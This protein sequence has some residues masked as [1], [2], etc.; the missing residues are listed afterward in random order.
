MTNRKTSTGL[1]TKT[2]GEIAAAGDLATNTRGTYERAWSE[3]ERWCASKR[4]STRPGRSE[5][6]RRR[7]A[8][9]IID[10]LHD[11]Y[12]RDISV[13]GL[14]IRRNAIAWKLRGEISVRKWRDEVLAGG[15][16]IDNPATYESVKQYLRG[17][18]KDAGRQ[19]KQ[20]ERLYP[21]QV[22]SACRVACEP[23][24][25]GNVVESAEDA[26]V[27]G[28]EDRA[29]LSFLFYGLMRRSEVS[30]LR[31]RAVE[32]ARD[33]DRRLVEV[34]V[35]RA[36]NDPT[37]SRVDR[38]H[39]PEPAAGRILDLRSI[40]GTVHRDDFVFPSTR[41]RIRGMS[42]GRLNDRF[43]AS[44]ERVGV[45]GHSAH[46]GRVGMAT[47]M[48][49]CGMTDLQ[50]ARAG[51]WRSLATV[52]RYTEGRSDDSRPV[53]ELVRMLETREAS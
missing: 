17:A 35:E 46:S 48:S 5:R 13:S 9:R 44:L 3:F 47:L 16:H 45:R 8:V 24:A 39:I 2:K 40:R 10:F 34:M 36:K 15:V 1:R 38:R 12:C 19:P 7:F 41:S 25:V 29:I 18:R 26:R 22:E 28:I 37:A 30:M 20:A 43:K 52:K 14:S 6:D 49:E 50:I 51:G 21:E 31:W 33:D 4:L 42:G 23:R 11:E 32:P 27:R 53:V